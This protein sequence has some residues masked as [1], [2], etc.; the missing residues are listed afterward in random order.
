MKKIAIVL[1][2]WLLLGLS[3]CAAKIP[4]SGFLAVKVCTERQCSDAS[5]KPGPRESGI[6]KS[7]AELGGCECLAW[8][9]QA[10]GVQK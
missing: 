6:W 8:E 10:P 1:V 9:L 3:A 2:P 4:P 5:G 7:A